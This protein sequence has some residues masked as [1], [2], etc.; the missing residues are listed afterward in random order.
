M[1]LSYLTPNKNMNLSYLTPNKNMNLSYLTPNTN[2]NLSYLTPNK[3]MN[4]SYLTPNKNQSTGT[5][6]SFEIKIKKISFLSKRA[7]VMGFSAEI[8]NHKN[9]TVF[10]IPFG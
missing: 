10:K 6:V 9:R 5:F 4:L 7:R 1:N 2:M 3:N 8:S